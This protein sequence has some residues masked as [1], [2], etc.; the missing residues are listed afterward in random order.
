MTTCFKLAL[1]QL[2][3][4]ADKKL[5]LRHARAAVQ[6]AAGRG[7]RLAAL[8]EMFNCPYG[9]RYF[10]AYAEEFPDGETIRCLAGL[11]KEY[12]IYLVGGSIPERSAGRLYNTSFVFGPD[13]N[14][15]ARHR[16]IHLFDIDIPGGIS[17][18]ESATLAAGNSLTLFTT[19][20]CR[21]GVAICYDIRFPELTRAMALQGIHLL[22]LPAAFNMTTGPAHWELTMRAR[23]LDNQIFVA[24]VS[25]ARDN[26]AEYVAYGHS[27]VT[28]PWGEVLVQ[29][30]DGPAVLTADIDLAQLHRIREQLPLLKHR[31]EDVYFSI[32]S[33]S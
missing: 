14:L 9:N 24:A 27:M 8:P 19:P 12:G 15:L 6:E 22:V 28:S 17:F 7:C 25:P 31:R 32:G 5:N 2:Q 30:A 13:G 26:Q 18:K 21:I 16:K 4:T 1:C 23:A 11:A 20:F 33:T 29:A 3:V 10:P